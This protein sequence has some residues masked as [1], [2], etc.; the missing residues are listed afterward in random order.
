MRCNS[1]HPRGAEKG[2]EIAAAFNPD[3]T[4]PVWPARIFS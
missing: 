2:Q 1:W 4:A 3:P